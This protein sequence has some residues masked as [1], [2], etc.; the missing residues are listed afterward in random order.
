MVVEK[1]VL[2]ISFDLDGT[3][4]PLYNEFETEKLSG[5]AR[6]FGIEPLRKGSKPL[7]KQLQQ[8]G[9]SVHVY[10]TSYRKKFKIRLIFWYHGITL[11]TIITQPE[12]SIALRKIG[13]H[14]SKYPPAFGFDIHIDDSKGVLQKGQKHGFTV[15]QIKS[16]TL[17][18]TKKILV[19]L[20]QCN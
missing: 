14:G 19:A 20:K 13:Y 11:K 5:I 17:N 9:H 16:G 10:T 12:N 6:L 2:N 18:W 8:N 1:K 4:I 7:I 3:L 15:I